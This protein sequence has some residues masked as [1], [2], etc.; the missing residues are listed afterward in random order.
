MKNII[1]ILGSPNS[2]KGW[3]SKIAIGRAKKCLEIF[4]SAKD[5]ILCTGGFGVH[6]NT[7]EK[8]HAEYLKRY[9]IKNGISEECFLPFANSCNTVEDAT[10]AKEILL[11]YGVRKVTIITT[12]YHLKRVQLIFDEIL[13]EFEITYLDVP[14]NMSVKSLLKFEKHEAKAVEGIL[15]DGL[16][17]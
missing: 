3:L 4:D 1:I 14:N 9:L 10:K 6:F 13:S 16:Y 2:P 15:R 11:E 8:P 7:S 12:H 17:Y 5:M